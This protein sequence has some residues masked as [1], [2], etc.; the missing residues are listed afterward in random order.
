[1]KPHP[2][3]RKTIKWG[4]AAVTLVLVVVWIGSGWWTLTWL[5]PPS[6]KIQIRVG[7]IYVCHYPSGGLEDLPRGFLTP[8]RELGFRMAFLPASRR[9]P[10]GVHEALCPLWILP[11]GTALATAAAWVF[12][13][14]ARRRAR[15]NLCPKCTYDRAGLAAGAKCP[16][17]GEPPALS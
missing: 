14:R 10:R 16:E 4:G 15:L 17:C 2:R 1:M 13:S 3:I 11:A 9:M 6:I 8:I 12:D 7:S 5:E